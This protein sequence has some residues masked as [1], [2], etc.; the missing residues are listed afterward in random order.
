MLQGSFSSRS[1]RIL[2]AIVTVRM[3]GVGGT[4]FGKTHFLFGTTNTR[5][6]QSNPLSFPR[7][8]RWRN[9]SHEPHSPSRGYA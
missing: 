5:A 2:E 7:V 9:N 4:R 6:Q 3:T 8:V 1:L